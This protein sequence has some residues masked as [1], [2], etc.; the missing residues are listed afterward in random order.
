MTDVPTNCSSCGRPLFR[1]WWSWSKGGYECRYCGGITGPDGAA[2]AGPSAASVT[3]PKAGSASALPKVIAVLVGLGIVVVVL[4][5]L[6]GVRPRDGD[7][8]GG[9]PVDTYMD[10]YGGS[11]AVYANIL[12][13]TDCDA[14]QDTFDQASANNYA[15]EPGSEAFSW[16]TGYMSA[17][18]DRMRAIGC[19]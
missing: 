1:Q 6:G 18:D 13:E 17:A 11:R 14:L 8:G 9:S 12:S 5:N 15:A 16:T 3:M 2:V 10:D 4:S 19:Y 7:G